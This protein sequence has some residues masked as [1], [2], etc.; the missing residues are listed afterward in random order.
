[1]YTCHICGLQTKLNVMLS[2]HYKKHHVNIIKSEYKRN[3]LLHNG[4][5]PKQC[6]FCGKETTINKGESEYNNFCSRQCYEQYMVGNNNSNWTGGKITINCAFCGKEVKKHA[7]SFQSELRFCSTSCSTKYYYC[8]HNNIN[9]EDYS[10]KEY[11]YDYYRLEKLRKICFEKANYTCNI[12]GTRNVELNAHHLNNKKFFPELVYDINNLTCI[13]KKC[14]YKLH[15]VYGPGRDI[16]VT[17]K[18]Y[19]EFRSRY[20]KVHR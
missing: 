14:H 20:E 9:I 8:Q 5:A 1:M 10:P 2:S 13:C 3:L 16:P 19:N 17:E 12:C 15:S 6:Q 18:D 4:R 11:D 7:S